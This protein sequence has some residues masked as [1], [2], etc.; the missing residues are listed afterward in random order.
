VPVAVLIVNY[1]TYD[2]LDRCLASLMPHLAS[3][4]EVVVVDWVS[5]A[6]R[7]G[8]LASGYPAVRWIVRTDNLGFS[9]GI[10][11]AARTSTA[12]ILLLLNPDTEVEGPVVRTLDAWLTGNP[13]SA[14]VGPKVTN[15][16]G[17]VQPSARSFPG[18]STVFGGRSTWLTRRF[19][20][21][22]FSRRNLVR[23]GS[24]AAGA[25]EVDW[26]AGSCFATPRSVFTQLGGLDESFF[27]YWEDA[28]YCRR[29]TALGLRCFYLPTTTVRHTGGVSS[30]HNVVPSI[31]AFHRSAFRLYWKHTRLGRVVAPLVWLGLRV[32][33]EVKVMMR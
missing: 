25:T 22:W 20:N 28:D 1:R 18:V 4:D 26:L 32:R 16:D 11:L 15:A 19:P 8:V 31:R 5:D 7:R 30:A 17:S 2:A 21:N 12:E 24:E 33:G 13:A 10:N 23:P 6:G 27:M 9:A 3:D 14:A 29:A